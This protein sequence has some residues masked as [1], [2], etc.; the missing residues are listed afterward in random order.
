MRGDERIKSFVLRVEVPYGALATID[1]AAKT[2]LHGRNRRG[3]S[4]SLLL[5]GLRT[6]LDWERK[7]AGN[8]K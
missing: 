4:E 6:F 2:G 7:V 1:R 3:V 8:P 5:D